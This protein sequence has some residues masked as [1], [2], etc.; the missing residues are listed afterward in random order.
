MYRI[1]TEKIIYDNETEYINWINDKPKLK[2]YGYIFHETSTKL[3]I[4]E[5]ECIVPFDVNMLEEE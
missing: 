3:S 1:I 4:A 5:K 2:K